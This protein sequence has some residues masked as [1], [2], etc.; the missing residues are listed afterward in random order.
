MRLTQFSDYSFRLMMIASAREGGLVTIEEV[1]RVFNISRAHLMKV[2]NGLTKAGF[3][4]AVRGRSGGLTMARSPAEIRL[5]DI[6]RATEPDF[7]LVECF[8]TGNACIITRRCR[9]KGILHEALSAF[10]EK[11]DAYT[12]ADL[13]LRPQDFGLNAET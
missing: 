9:L 10:I 8:S 2:A 5:G 3:L 13:M 4:R 1:S 7:A 6:I 12:L 11:L